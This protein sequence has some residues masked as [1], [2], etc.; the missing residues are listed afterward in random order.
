MMGYQK[1]FRTWLAHLRRG[2]AYRVMEAYQHAMLHPLFRD[3]TVS[4]GWSA[5]HR[6]Q[7]CRYNK[8]IRPSARIGV[9]DRKGI[10][11]L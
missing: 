4:A 10:W 2:N 8:I 7:P 3:C 5:H 11:R 1:M 6:L 9:W